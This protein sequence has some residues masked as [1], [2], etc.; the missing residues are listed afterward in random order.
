[1][2]SREYNTSLEMV[3]VHQLLQ[4]YLNVQSIQQKTCSFL[5]YND[6]EENK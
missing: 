3:Q 5:F 1:M 4:T 6:M 2:N